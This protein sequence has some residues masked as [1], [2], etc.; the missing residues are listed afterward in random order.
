[1][2]TRC[3]IAIEQENGTIKSIY[4]HHDGYKSGVGAIL[5]KHYTDPDKVA[6]LIELGDLSSLGTFYDKKLAEMRWKEWDLPEKERHDLWALTEGMTL[7]YT[8]RGEDH[9]VRTD[10]NI[11]E[12]M[13]KI[14]K[15]GEEY[16]YLFTKD[17]T[18]VYG[19]EVCETPYFEPLTGEEDD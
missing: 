18:G 3:R 16:T 5:R 4:C 19:W 6:E 1:M 2:S 15:T 11:V 8:D 9:Q 7:P 10:E 12:F 17:Y 14:G 13:R